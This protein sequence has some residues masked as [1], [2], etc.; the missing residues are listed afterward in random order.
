MNL[1][2]AMLIII[3]L[4][5]YLPSWVIGFFIRPLYKGFIDGFNYTEDH[6]L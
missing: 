3:L 6:L 1:T 4:P 2:T 5:F